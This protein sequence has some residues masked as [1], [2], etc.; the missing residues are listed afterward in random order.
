MLLN[1]ISNVFFLIVKY[2]IIEFGEESGN[3]GEEP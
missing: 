1:S 3:D 2:V